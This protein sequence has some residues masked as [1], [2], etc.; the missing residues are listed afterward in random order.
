MVPMMLYDVG[1]PIVGSII[2]IIMLATK[3]L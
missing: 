3:K 2:M 1:V